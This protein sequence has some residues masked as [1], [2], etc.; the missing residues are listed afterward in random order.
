MK[1]AIPTYDGKLCLHF[2][3]SESF[4]LVEVED[5]EIKN[6]EFLKP[7]D[8]APG[9]LPE[10]LH[11]QGADIIIAGGMGT[12]AQALFQQN[13]IDVIVGATPMEPEEVVKQYIDGALKMGENVCDH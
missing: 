12:R 2:G 1:I 7:P 13:G 8:H 4:A 11:E 5:G 6:V 10:W 3:H 9:V